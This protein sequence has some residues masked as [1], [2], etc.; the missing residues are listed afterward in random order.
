MNQTVETIFTQIGNP[1][2]ALLGAKQFVHSDTWLQFAV[3]KNPNRISKFRVCYEHGSDT[4][5]VEVIGK[6]RS[7][8]LTQHYIIVRH[9][10][11]YADQL[12]DLFETETGLLTR[13]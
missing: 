3:G 7:R 12:L 2:F 10:G 4:Y 9:E 13:F 11:I 8:G 5:T 1:A 6:R